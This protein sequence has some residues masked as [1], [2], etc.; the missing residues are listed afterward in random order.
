MGSGGGLFGGGGGGGGGNRA[1]QEAAARENARQERIEFLENRPILSLFDMI[2][3]L[4]EFQD[5]REN[6]EGQ[7]NPFSVL[8]QIFLDFSK[9]SR[10]IQRG[11]PLPTAQA[12]STGGGDGGLSAGG[13]AKSIFLPTFGI[14]G[15][16]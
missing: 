9:R 10:E 8:S 14:G 15:G 12:Q 7:E 2:P 13:A 3:G 5:L 16:K 11:T 1:A 6:R 4:A